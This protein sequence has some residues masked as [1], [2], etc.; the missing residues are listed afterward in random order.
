MGAVT[1]GGGQRASA[2]LGGRA[3]KAP[4]TEAQRAALDAGRAKGAEQRRDE[5]EAGMAAARKWR[6]EHH[7][8]CPACGRRLP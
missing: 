3:S 2:G 8:Q 5:K 7:P 1:A 6:D 4:P